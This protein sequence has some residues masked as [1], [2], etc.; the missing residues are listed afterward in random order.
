MDDVKYVWD[1]K[2]DGDSVN[3]GVYFVAHGDL[4]FDVVSSSGKQ[5]GGMALQHVAG[6]PMFYLLSVYLNSKGVD[7]PDLDFGD[8]KAFVGSDQDRHAVEL[9]SEHR[10]H[11]R[12]G[13]VVLE[14][15]INDRFP[16]YAIPGPNY[17]NS[18]PAHLT[19]DGELGFLC[20]K[21][22]EKKDKTLWPEYCMTF[23]KRDSVEAMK[24]LVNI[25]RAEDVP[26]VL[27]GFKRIGDFFKK[28]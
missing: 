23:S 17:F 5:V 8:L 21:R 19:R 9:I 13:R 2:L 20:E 25:Y 11:V 4:A 16:L 3:K 24:G 6:T 28:R 14:E 10:S 26:V 27:A 12:H 18:Y 1:S 7:I 15:P 22:G